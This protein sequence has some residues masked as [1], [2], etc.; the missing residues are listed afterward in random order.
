[1][2][3][4]EFNYSVD[5]LKAIIWQ[6][7][8]AENLVGLMNAYQEWRN[9]NHTE[10]WE[11]WYTDVFDLRTAN[12]FGLK[13]WS[14]ILGVPLVGPAS[15]GKDG[16]A[17][18]FGAARQNFQHGNFGGSGAPVQLQ[19]EQ[20]R[21]VL[22]LRYY[23]LVSRGTIPET[24]A[25][26]KVLFEDQ[27]PVYVED[28]LDMT[29]NFVFGFELDATV[30]YVFDRMDML[31]RPSG[32]LATYQSVPL[33]SVPVYGQYPDE[34]LAVLLD[35]SQTFNASM[36]NCTPYIVNIGAFQATGGELSIALSS[37]S[38]S[39]FYKVFVDSVLAASGTGAD[40]VIWD[41]TNEYYS[42]SSEVEVILYCYQQSDVAS[43]NIDFIYTE[44]AAC[45]LPDVGSIPIDESVSFDNVRP[46]ND[47]FSGSLSSCGTFATYLTATWGVYPRGVTIIDGSAVGLKWTVFKGGV[48]YLSGVYEGGGNL[49]I[50]GVAELPADP[51]G[52]YTVVLQPG[53]ADESSYYEIN[54]MVSPR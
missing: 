51:S 48:E 25:F 38:G 18:A 4:Q 17:W 35:A 23:Q 30:R 1:M 32:V 49:E 21:L 42:D 28:N 11:N 50:M 14:I 34:Y 52:Y 13:V 47:T 22:R 31:P 3:D 45:E 41:Y 36:A 39:Y 9:T 2:R 5:L 33:C 12:S 40:G 6:Y 44:T 7:D 20:A 19:D 26:L 16:P 29:M 37:S 43:A 54:F 8:S 27:G 46:V 24:N 53:L 15:S 10:F